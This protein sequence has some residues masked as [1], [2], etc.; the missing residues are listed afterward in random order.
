MHSICTVPHRAELSISQARMAFSRMR[1][2]PHGPSPVS[3]VS[4]ERCSGIQ[5]SSGQ[6]DRPLLRCQ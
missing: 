1:R 6:S 2:L 4:R 3:L 5:C